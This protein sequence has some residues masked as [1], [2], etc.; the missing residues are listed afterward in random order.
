[1]R[2]EKDLAAKSHCVRSYNPEQG[3]RKSPVT[4]RASGGDSTGLFPVPPSK[5]YAG[6]SPCRT[7]GGR[8]VLKPGVKSVTIK[9]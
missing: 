6:I 5:I 1:M 8:K 4:A 7:K 2:G 3:R 9:N